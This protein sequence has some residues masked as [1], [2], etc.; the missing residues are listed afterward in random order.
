MTGDNLPASLTKSE[1]A[2]ATVDAPDAAGVPA[3]YERALTLV[4][5]SALADPAL[6]DQHRALNAFPALSAKWRELSWGERFGNEAPAL[7]VYNG[8]SVGSPQMVPQATLDA[9]GDLDRDVR[10]RLGDGRLR[11]I[12]YQAPRQLDAEPVLLPSVLVASATVNW[13][14]GTLEAGGMLFHQA[15]VLRAEDLAAVE[16]VPA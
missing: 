10:A 6:L 4:E 11:V 14:L 5:C 2:A 7:P 12:G 16:T 13:R 15:R 3:A 9:A 8:R 1:R